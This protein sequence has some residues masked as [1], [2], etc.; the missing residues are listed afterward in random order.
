[1]RLVFPLTLIFLGFFGSGSGIQT[2]KDMGDPRHNVVPYEEGDGRAE[3]AAPK[4]I[5]IFPEPPVLGAQH[6]WLELHGYGRG[7]ATHKQDNLFC[8]KLAGE[9]KARIAS[10]R[11]IEK[12]VVTG[13]ADG[14]V[15]HGLQ[16]GF[17]TVP[18][19]C[20][21][22]VSVP[23]DDHELALLRGCTILRKLSAKIALPTAGGISWKSEEHDEPDGG[24]EGEPYRKARV[25]VYLLRRKL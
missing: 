1:M 18:V 3:E 11:R 17:G 25:D 14:I 22:G 10:G 24:Y 20:L 16:D 7:S 2:S 12:I 23:I 19:D 21:E 9:I 13:F 8:E 15:N 4:R 5:G 6:F